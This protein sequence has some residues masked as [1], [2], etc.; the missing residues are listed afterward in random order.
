[1]QLNDEPL[2]EW[3]DIN[4]KELSCKELFDST[5]E[6]TNNEVVEYIPFTKTFNVSV[7]DV[8]NGSTYT[9]EPVSLQLYSFVD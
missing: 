7:Y 4:Y 2:D 9:I 8:T 5:T 6:E 3:I 1:M